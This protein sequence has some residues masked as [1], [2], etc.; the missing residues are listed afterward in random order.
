MNGLKLV[1]TFFIS[2]RNDFLL[3]SGF[4]VLFLLAAMGV[5]FEAYFIKQ[6]MM[7]WDDFWLVLRP[8]LFAVAGLFLISIWYAW[9]A[10]R[11]RF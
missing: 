1:A 10:Y 6:A 7:P 2:T 11:A 8:R 5:A 9:G 4:A 3:A